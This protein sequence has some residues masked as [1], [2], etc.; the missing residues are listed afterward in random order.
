MGRDHLAG[1]QQETQLAVRGGPC[2]SRASGLL[3]KRAASGRM[4]PDRVAPGGG[5]T[6]PILAFTFTSH[7]RAPR[8]S[9]YRQTSLDRGTRFRGGQTGTRPWSLR[10]PGLARLPSSCHPVYRRI[11]VPHRR[12]E[13]LFPLGA[14][15][16][17]PTT[18]TE[19]SRD[20]PPARPRRFATHG[21]IPPP[22]PRSASPSR[23]ISRPN[24]QVAFSRL[25]SFITEWY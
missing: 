13:P 19:N 1:R 2:S 3:A 17:D 11:R 10:G 9:A 4:A 25:A 6:R 7:N 22:S 8:T 12:E 14:C 20:V 18:R 24:F 15:W 16:P 23:V 21:I 5:G